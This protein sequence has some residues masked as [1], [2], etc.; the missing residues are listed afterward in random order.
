LGDLGPRGRARTPVPEN[1]RGARVGVEPRQ[2]P[3]VVRLVE[4]GHTTLAELNN[5]L[6][7]SA[8]VVGESA[9]SVCAI[10]AQ[11]TKCL[12]KVASKFRH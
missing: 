1:R 5:L 9:A 4:V 2:S 8:E 10:A 3:V 6:P 11:L 12:G 7:A